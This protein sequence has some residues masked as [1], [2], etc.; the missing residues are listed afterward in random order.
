MNNKIIAACVVVFSAIFFGLSSNITEAEDFIPAKENGKCAISAFNNALSAS[1]AVF[2]GTVK[3]EKKTGDTKIFQF[4]VE[5]YWK[6]SKK[7]KI[8]IRV[9]ETMRYQA[10][11]EVG[12]KYLVYAT[13]G[14]NGGL[15]VGRCSRSKDAGDASDD[16]QKLGKGK[17]PK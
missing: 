12:E 3:S 7:K 15:Y 8:E 11:F 6:G 10:F 4:E 5:R 17:R 13:A 16:L 14:E 9:H 1:A 2:V